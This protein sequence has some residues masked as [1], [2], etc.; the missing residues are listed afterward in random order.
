M[1]ILVLAY[2]PFLT[3]LL[4]MYHQG[5][6]HKTV[7]PQAMAD[8]TKGEIVLCNEDLVATT[9]AKWSSLKTTIVEWLDMMCLLMC[10]CGNYTHHSCDLLAR[11]FT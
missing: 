10:C 9:L 2:Y 7:H 3:S 11:Y 5:L 6:Y 4:S 8:W 1:C